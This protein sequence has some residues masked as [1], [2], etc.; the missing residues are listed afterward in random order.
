MNEYISDATKLS[1][2][3]GQFELWYNKLFI[4]W[5]ENLGWRY[6]RGIEK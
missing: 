4:Y 6:I 1:Q 5:N 3:M 2:P